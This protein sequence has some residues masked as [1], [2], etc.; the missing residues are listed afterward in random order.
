MSD[1]PSKKSVAIIGA[2]NVASTLAILATQNNYQVSIG[3]RNIKQAEASAKLAGNCKTGNI[4]EIV[5]QANFILIAVSDDAIQTVCDELSDASAF[6][7]G[8]VVAH[9]SGALDS[10]ILASAEKTANCAIASMH[11]LQSFPDVE[12]TLAS[13]QNT[14]CY[15]EGNPA[16]LDTIKSFANDISLQPVL[17]NKQAKALYHLVGVAACNYLSSLMDTALEIGE[18]A[19]IDRNTMWQSLFPLVS[20]T[21]D[22]IDKHGPAAALT[23]PIE[24]GDITTIKRHV[25]ALLNT[26]PEISH[27]YA[28]LGVQTTRLAL[29]KNSISIEIAEKILVE[30]EKLKA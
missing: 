26:T 22:N 2:G 29:R 11:P 4:V 8:A 24:R 21:L 9:C 10:D 12:S 14:Y 28:T 15:Y 1:K 5:K 7:E 13:I 18:M 19:D 23:G 20:A 17:I 25:D 6:T 30:L 3:A 16:A 27:I